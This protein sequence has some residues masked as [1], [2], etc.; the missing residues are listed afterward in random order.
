M[1]YDDEDS[2]IDDESDGERSFSSDGSSSDEEKMVLSDS[3]GEGTSLGPHS[4]KGTRRTR[5]KAR[6]VLSLD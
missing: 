4:K 2:F 6:C 3:G 5:A 1:K